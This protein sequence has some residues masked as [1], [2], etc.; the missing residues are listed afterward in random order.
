MIIITGG[1]DPDVKVTLPNLKF[2][3]RMELNHTDPDFTKE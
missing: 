3:K 1:F 2:T